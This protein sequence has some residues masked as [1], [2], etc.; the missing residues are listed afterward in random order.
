MR[1]KYAE[2]SSYENI[3]ETQEESEEDDEV[4]FRFFVNGEIVSWAK[5]L[6]CSHLKEIRTAV[7]EKRKGYDGKLLSHMEKVAKEHGAIE[8]KACYV[9]SWSD[10]AAVFFRSKAVRSLS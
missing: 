10:E 8:M 6:F 2:N 5:T 3:I 9:G 1:V 7:G 4:I